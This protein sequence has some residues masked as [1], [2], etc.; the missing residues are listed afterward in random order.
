MVGNGAEH[1][2]FLFLLGGEL[3]Q[4]ALWIKAGGQNGVPLFLGNGVAG[5]HHGGGTMGSTEGDFF[6]LSTGPEQFYES[7]KQ[8]SLFFLF[9]QFEPVVAYR[10]E[11]HALLSGDLLILFFLRQQT[12]QLQLCRGESQ[13]TGRQREQIVQHGAVGFLQMQGCHG[14][15]VVKMPVFWENLPF[16]EGSAADQAVKY[17]IPQDIALYQFGDFGRPEAFFIHYKAHHIDV[18]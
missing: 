3:E 18:K 9:P 14:F 7:K 2:Q 10:G 5:V 17:P 15:R 6:R 13:C 12:D 1:H 11:G 8:L 4:R 16:G